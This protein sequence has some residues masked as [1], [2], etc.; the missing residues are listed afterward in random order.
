[1]STNDLN[2]S[3]NNQG[4]AEICLQ[5]PHKHNAINERMI[6]DMTQ[7]CKTLIDKGT[8]VNALLIHAQGDNFCAGAD[9]QWMRQ[10]FAASE[11]EQIQQSSK[12]AHLLQLL[13]ELP[14]P[15]ISLVKG[16]VFGGGLGI[17]AISDRVIAS[18]DAEFCFSEVLLGLIPATIAPYVFAKSG[19]AIRG[20]FL[21]AHRFDAT[22]AKQLQL[23][24]EIV[25]AAALTQAATHNIDQVLRCDA[26]AIKQAKALL[27]RLSDHQACNQASAVMIR[28]SS[29]PSRPWRV[30]GKNRQPDNALNPF[31]IVIN[32]V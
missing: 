2:L 27:Q 18:D 19:N 5:R 30:A 13:N 20:Y 1:M 28:L 31:S 24:T 11:A 9:L 17:V 16:K 25:P 22:V 21:T 3:V 10:Q 26:A 29:T 6:D 8:Q 32:R 14:M 12:L 15:V 23:V 7:F 4:I